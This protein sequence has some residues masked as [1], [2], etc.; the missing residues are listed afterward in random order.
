MLYKSAFAVVLS[1]LV[2]TGCGSNEVSFET[3]ESARSV[4]NDNAKFNATK[5]R[6]ENGFE[7]FGLLVRGDS[8]QTNSCPQGDGWASVDL[9]DEYKQPYRKLKCSTVSSN[10][11]CMTV[12]DFK[13]RQQYAS[14]ENQCNHTLPKM[15]KR[16]EQ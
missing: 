16:I 4:A 15:P 14:Q 6:A 5:F 7:K 1:S 13:S 12:E 10:I 11:G 3:L 9:L 8:S 2:L